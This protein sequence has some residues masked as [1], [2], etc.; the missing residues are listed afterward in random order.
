M[1]FS[2][3]AVVRVRISSRQYRVEPEHLDALMDN[4]AVVLEK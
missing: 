1:V 2:A 4:C 3:A